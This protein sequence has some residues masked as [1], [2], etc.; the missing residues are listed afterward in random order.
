MTSRTLPTLLQVTKST[1]PKAGPK[2]TA[3]TIRTP[4]NLP[5][6]TKA[7]VELGAY[8]A[9]GYL[10]Q[11]L[12]LLTADASRAALLSTFTVL[13]VP[14]LA[15]LNGTKVKPLVWLC[16]LG[17]IAG[18]PRRCAP[19]HPACQSSTPALQLGTTA[20][21]LPRAQ[22]MTLSQYPVQCLELKI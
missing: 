19:D 16:C 7:G 17:S 1:L 11:S 21:F 10:F 5:Q 15:A 3:V 20:T 2:S 9:G 13:T 8:M 4:P 12:A 22:N 18:V 14:V 6:V